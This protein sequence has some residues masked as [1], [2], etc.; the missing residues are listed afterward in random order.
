MRVMIAI[1]L[2]SLALFTACSTR[3]KQAVEAPPSYQPTPQATAVRMGVVQ[4]PKLLEVQDAVKRVFKDAAVIDSSHNPNFLAGDFNGDTSQDIAVIVKPAKLDDMN[5]DLPPWLVREPRSDKTP[6]M[7]R[8]IEKD[9]VLLAVI[10][11]YGINDWRDPQATQ[12][13]F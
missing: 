13:F 8:R 1:G 4:A 12:T 10:H 6:V 3:P 11:G 5:Q 2:I 9:E 7:R